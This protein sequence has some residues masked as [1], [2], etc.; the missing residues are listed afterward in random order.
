M[1]QIRDGILVADL[2][3]DNANNA[4]NANRKAGLP[5]GRRADSSSS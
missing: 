4:N 2:A 1:G 3:S 5:P